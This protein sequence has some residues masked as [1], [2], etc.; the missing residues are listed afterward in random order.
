VFSST[1]A[2]TMNFAAERRWSL[3]PCT[4]EHIERMGGRNVV[5]GHV[6]NNRAT[7]C[8]STGAP[9]TAPAA[10]PEPF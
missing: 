1:S 9:L 6:E 8:T 3:V 7:L 10:D 5:T 4:P 2:Y